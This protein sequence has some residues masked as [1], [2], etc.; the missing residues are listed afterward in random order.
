LLDNAFEILKQAIDFFGAE[1]NHLVARPAGYGDRSNFR[2]VGIVFVLAFLIKLITFL[3]SGSAFNARR[4]AALSAFLFFEFFLP[5]L[6][7]NPFE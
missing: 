6:A 1:A 3:W 5:S 7:K 4:T 2:Y